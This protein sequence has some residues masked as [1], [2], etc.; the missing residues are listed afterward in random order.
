MSVW[1]KVYSFLNTGQQWGFDGVFFKVCDGSV[2]RLEC[3]EYV[4]SSRDSSIQVQAF[5]FLFGFSSLS[6]SL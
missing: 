2:G 1:L 6:Q 5:P 3:L 4:L